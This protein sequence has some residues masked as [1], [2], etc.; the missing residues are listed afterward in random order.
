MLYWLQFFFFGE[1]F[2]LFL[3]FDFFIVLPGN[4]WIIKETEKHCLIL[5]PRIFTPKKII[6]N[7]KILLIHWYTEFIEFSKEKKKHQKHLIQLVCGADISVESFQHFSL[8]STLLTQLLTL[9]KL[10]CSS[11]WRFSNSFSTNSAKFKSLGKM[12]PEG[13]A[14]SDHF[15]ICGSCICVPSARRLPLGPLPLIWERKG[16]DARPWRLCGL[17][18]ISPPRLPEQWLQPPEHRPG[19]GDP[20]HFREASATSPGLKVLTTARQVGRVLPGWEEPA[21]T[22]LDK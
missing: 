11:L 10:P 12:T 6:K 1:Y 19:N 14:S 15:D 9:F 5:F 4:L 20:E 18:P 22:G 7:I 13:T 17:S 16:L 3:Y 8:L 21:R 2:H